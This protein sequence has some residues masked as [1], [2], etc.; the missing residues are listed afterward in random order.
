M[1]DV[2]SSSANNRPVFSPSLA[3]QRHPGPGQD[4]QVGLRAGDPPG[5]WWIVIQRQ[6]GPLYV[7]RIG[8]NTVEAGGRVTEISLLFNGQLSIFGMTAA[9]DRL[10]IT[11]H[12][13]DVLAIS[14]WSVDLMGLAISADL[15]GLMLA[16]GLLK[17]VD[18]TS[19]GYVGMLM[20][21]FA[22]YGLSVFG[23][24]TQD[25][26]NA[27][28]FVFGAINGP[29]GGPPAFFLT[30]LGGG[31]GINRGL[32]IP[33][34]ISQFGTFPF[35]QALDPG[36]KPPERP[37]DELH[38][39]SSIFPHQMGNFW[40]AAGISFT[41]FSLV[42]GVA[43]VAVSF[44]NGL[45]INLLGLARMALPRPGAALVS[46]EL[47]LLARFSTRE[48]VFMIKAQL[49][50]NS[51]LLT[52]SIRLTGG[53]AFA[54]W[55]KGPLA[56]QFVLTMGGYHPSFHRDGYPDVPRL[57]IM[58]RISDY[59]VIKGGSYFALTS[60]A[61]MAGTSIE[62][63]LDLGFV[64]AKLS[65]GADGIIYFDP[66]WFEVSAYCR[67]S[68][69]IN[70]DLGLFTISFS[71]T[72]GATIKVWGPD[73][74]GRAEFE[75]GPCTIPV[76][77]GSK[78]KVKGA[79]L[80][81]TDFVLKYLEDAGGRARALSGI[82]GRGTLPA[83]TG[84]KTA[85]PSSDGT[86]GLPYRVFAEFELTFVT[87]I[88]TQSMVIGTA[89]PPAVAVTLPDGTTARLGL[90]PMN[91]AKLTSTLTISLE[92]VDPVTHATTSTAADGQPLAT[93]LARLAERWGQ[94]DAA[95]PS[96]DA[97][98]I[99]AWGEPEPANLTVKPL[100]AGDVLRTGNGMRLVA[101]VEMPQVGPDINYYQVEAGRRPLPLLATGNQRSQFL[102]V[103]AALPGSAPGSAAAALELAADRLFADRGAGATLRRRGGHSAL[104]AAAF[105]GERSAPPLFGTLTDGLAK[106]NGADGIREEQEPPAEPTGRRQ[107]SPFVAGYL[108]GGSGAAI[109]SL[110]TTVGDGR[111]KRRPAPTVESV[112]GRLGRSLPLPLT[113]AATP[114]AAVEGTVVAA[115]LVP[116]TDA[117]GSAG[118][119]AG[120]RFG[121][122]ALQAVVTGLELTSN[123]P[124]AASR[125]RRRPKADAL[126]S[127]VRSGDLVVP[128]RPDARTD[129]DDER[130]PTLGVTGKARVSMLRGNHAVLDEDVTDATVTVPAG[131]T[132]L[133]VHADG[134]VDHRRLGRLALG[135]RVARRGEPGRRRCRVPRHRRQRHRREHDGL[136]HRSTARPRRRPRR[137]ALLPAG[138]HRRD[139]ADRRPPP[140]P[141]PDRT[142]PPRRPGR[143]PAWR[144]RAAHRRD[145]RRHQRPRVCRGARHRCHLD[146]R[147]GRR[148]WRLVGR[149]RR[150]LRRLAGG[151]RRGHRRPTAERCHGQ[152][153]RRPGQH[154]PGLD[155]P[156]GP[157]RP[158]TR[159]HDEHRRGPLP[160]LLRV[161]PALGRALPLHRPQDLAADG[162]DG[163]LAA[164]AAG[165]TSAARGRHCR[166]TCS[167]PIRCSRSSAGRHSRA[168]GA[169]LPQVVKRRTLPWERQSDRERADTVAR[170]VAAEG[171][172]N[173]LTGL[174]AAE[175]ICRRKALRH[176]RSRRL[177]PEIRKSVI[178]RIM[179]ARKDVPLLAHA[180]EVDINDTELMMGDD[181]GFLAVVIANRLPLAGRAPDGSEVP[182]TYHACLVSLEN[183]FDRLLPESPPRSLVSDV[184]VLATN[185][186]AVSKAVHDHDVMQQD[187]DAVINPSIGA[188]EGVVVGPHA[189]SPHA[190]SP[191]DDAP[192]AAGA[193]VTA[194]RMAVVA[195]GG[196]AVTATKEWGGQ[197]IVGKVSATGITA[198]AKTKLVKAVTAF[199]PVHRFPC[200]LHWSWTTTGSQTFESLMKGVDSG[201]LGTTGEPRPPVEGRPPLEVVET[202]HVGL[203][204]RTRRGDLVRA[205]YR[206]P[207]LPHPADFTAPRLPLAHAA[208]Q[209]RL[210]VPDGR[211]DL[212]LASAFEIGRLLAL[213][214]PSMVAALLRWRQDGYQVARREA[215]WNGIIKD[216]DLGR[217][218]FV[219]RELF[220]GLGRGLVATL[221]VN[222]EEIIGPPKE[223]FTPG[224]SMGLDGR[225]ADLVAKGF[226][227]TARLDRGTAG[228]SACSA[229][230]TCPRSASATCGSRRAAGGRGVAGCRARGRRRPR[231]GRGALEVILGRP[232]GGFAGVGVPAGG[233]VFGGRV[234]IP[235]G[236]AIDEGPDALDEALRGARGESSDDEDG[237]E[238]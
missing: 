142:H 175:C 150:R 45:E 228:S 194:Y 15:G 132:H 20:G 213:S 217:D 148:R 185:T 55:W 164:A 223:V 166:A 227:I 61:L 204:Q 36:A 101:G 124:R 161:T 219:D 96:T 44:G 125:S 47:A 188:L 232:G 165:R 129:T 151:R 156:A 28:F 35:I 40:F 193:E 127:T 43:V 71:I 115:G 218:L 120:G 203:D 73:F 89:R 171:E 116:R 19:T 18:G 62:A 106:K 64:W 190:D 216:L 211:E 67:I 126:A 235:H 149:G 30:G 95:G 113:R 136:G 91:A 39:L 181:D 128:Q 49:T 195:D 33:E 236:E 66:F 14:S 109:R 38:R 153:P 60:E 191:H 8:L 152:A 97:F 63:S 237:D 5:P 118:R 93:K 25:G 170:A 57:G 48:G 159:G 75:I 184:L 186:V 157:R 87:T 103:S 52:E 140:R 178:D 210:V 10:S 155:R 167:R 224:R 84:G 100:P 112:S 107:R 1:N 158:R 105:A 121:N 74:A 187:I 85:A 12:G 169:R 182:V 201:L 99:G 13:G 147:Q 24:Y 68:A 56:G 111:I 209:L 205:W 197:K 23:G 78:R 146:H 59:L 179:P 88:P 3:I 192:H 81:W 76:E 130:R 21:R 173:F 108:T 208:D 122:A 72:L 83:A 58:W 34:D 198:G 215:V 90:S 79:P 32:V 238:S 53:F 199:D 196:K 51:W 174:P 31:L 144:P 138:E 180:R 163:A 80:P 98:P 29:I 221:A 214:Q 212:S 119:Y 26:P 139:R 102:A 133:A 222:P 220:L 135:N 189:D 86:I 177:G 131:V 233:G 65:F 82:T 7:D 160:P 92:L 183:Q 154:G 46:I 104:A 206:G 117:V 6:L 229:G 110:K 2:G 70:L 172:A 22:A 176:A 134:G 27:S 123:A 168:Y 137:D 114:A 207:L 16:G 11:W 226:G 94:A 143:D 37:M 145:H 69:G 230:W 231:G 162:P 225:A 77:F 141:R 50:D 202:G 54:I 4:V 9:V 41:C 234:V 200:L 17:I 42:D